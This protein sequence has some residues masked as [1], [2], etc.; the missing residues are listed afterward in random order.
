MQGQLV[1]WRNWRLRFGFNLREGLVLYQ[2]GFNDNGHVRPILYRAS[3]SEV[4]T[5]Y[6][7][8]SPF[9]SWM[10]I[11]DEGCFGLGATSVPVRP[12]HEVPAN[13]VT[14]SALVPD[15]SKSRFSDV[16]ARRIYLYE[17][18]G[19]N[20]IYWQ[21]DGR[22]VH[23]RA[24]EL[25]IGT[26]VSLGNY[27]YAFNWVFR[28]DGSFRFEA[29]LSGTILTKFVHGADCE[30]C[31]AIAQGPAANGESRI[32]APAGHD[33]FGG[34][35]YPHV[36]GVSH[37]HW[38]NLR[39]DFDIDGANNAVVE[40]NMAHAPANANS[41]TIGV[42]QTI[43]GKASQARREIDDES[44]RSWTVYNPAALGRGR[45]PSGYRVAPMGNTASM[46]ASAREREPIGFTLHHLWVTPYRD[47]ELFSAGRYPNQAPQSYTDGLATYSDQS[48]VYDRDVVLWYSLGDTH[49]PRAEDF[50]LMP[51]KT[52]SVTFEPDGFFEGNPIFG[53]PSRP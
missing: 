12:G 20:L 45:R 44:M 14:L 7:D 52:L 48:S 22:T 47:G 37:Q 17:R 4:L 5:A 26:I 19:G 34:L 43:F 11:F 46:F 51:S 33:D 27:F 49:V 21:Q 10:R 41:A 18:D 15:A 8:P 40:N 28:E 50:P 30:S 31:A 23:T 36:V 35:V 32:Y 6:G 13:A 1:S 29:E 42:A 16:L 53:R 3:V 38:F 25:V 9:W 39:L 2:I 24:T